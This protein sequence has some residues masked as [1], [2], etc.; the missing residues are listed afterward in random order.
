VKKRGR[1][2]DREEGLGEGGSCACN[3]SLYEMRAMVA[4]AQP[5]QLA[6]VGRYYH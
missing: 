5:G 3:E 1:G 4:R 2:W 6:R